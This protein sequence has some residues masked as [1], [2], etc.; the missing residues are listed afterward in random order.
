MGQAAWQGGQMSHGAPKPNHTRACPR[1]AS[2][3]QNANTERMWAEDE[4]SL[5]PGLPEPGRAGPTLSWL[6]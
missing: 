4:P 2:L 3:L 6:S 5:G 1:R